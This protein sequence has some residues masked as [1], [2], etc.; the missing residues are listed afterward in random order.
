[1]N[2]KGFSLVELL[3]VIVLLGVLAIIGVGAYTRYK[4]IAVKRAIDTLIKSSR[5]AAENYFFDNNGASSVTLEYLVDKGY[6]E[7][8]QDPYHTTKQCSG[9]VTKSNGG[10]STKEGVLTSYNYTVSITCS[11]HNFCK[12]YPEEVAC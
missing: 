6:L 1:M 7:N 4:D 11:G 3:G 8:R 5:Q 9:T 10:S 12:K 2:K